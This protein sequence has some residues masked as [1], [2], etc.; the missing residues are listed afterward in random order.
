MCIFYIVPKYDAKRDYNKTVKSFERGNKFMK[1]IRLG[2]AT[3]SLGLGV[4]LFAP[5]QANAM[6]TH[7]TPR[8]MRG[9]WYGYDKEYEFWERIHVT[10]HSFRYSSG[11]QGD[12]LRGRHLSVVYG[13]SHAHTTVAFQMTG[14]FGAT[15]SYHF[16]KAKVHGHYHTALIQDGSTAM[17]H[18]H[19]KHYYIPR[20]YQ[21]I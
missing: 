18:K 19:V 10:K 21:F 3:L 20:G 13:H 15:D 6:I 11:G 8:A 1:H 12:T 2:L 9:T 17:F 4:F 14:H 5:Q 16:G 7:T